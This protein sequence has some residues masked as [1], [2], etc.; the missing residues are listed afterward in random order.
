MQNYPPYTDEQL[1]ALLK[2]NDHAAFTE[3]YHRY[4]EKLF[5]VAHQ[6]TNDTDEAKEIVQKVFI[7]LWK[8]RNSL[9]L[10][11]TLPTYLSTAVKYEVLNLFAKLS[12]EARYREF[13]NLK[14]TDETTQNIIDFHELQ[15][16]VSQ[17]I[18]QLPEKCQLV[19]RMSREQGLS[20]KEIASE[21]DIS[22]KTVENHITLATKKLRTGLGKFLFQLFF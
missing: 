21:L 6:R 10:K 22:E 5:A 4:W 20:H 11:F 3:I 17:L 9:E 14:V 12:R 13:T 7:N 18:S 8:K 16:Q 1:V 15:Q 2:V 19:F